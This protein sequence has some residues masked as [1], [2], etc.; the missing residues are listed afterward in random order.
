M[1]EKVIINVNEDE[2]R[3]PKQVY[4]FQDYF[5]LWIFIYRWCYEFIMLLKFSGCTTHPESDFACGLYYL[6]I[7]IQHQEKLKIFLRNFTCS[8]IRLNNVIL[9]ALLLNNEGCIRIET[10]V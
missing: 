10:I 4:S 8:N 1:N 2:M 6:Y 9:D 3:V 7:L 5:E